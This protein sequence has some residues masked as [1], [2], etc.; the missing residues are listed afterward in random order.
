M[1]R[2]WEQQQQQEARDCALH[3]HNRPLQAAPPPAAS[4]LLACSI[5]RSPAWLSTFSLREATRETADFIKASCLQQ[6]GPGGEGK[7]GREAGGQQ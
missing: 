7:S 5:L 4:A 6:G 3:A 1:H 2:G